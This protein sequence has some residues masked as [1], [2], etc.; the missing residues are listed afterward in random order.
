MT[1]W[2]N[3]PS[4]YTNGEGVSG[5]GDFFFGFPHHILG[6]KFAFGLVVLIWTSFFGL[7]LAARSAKAML[8]ASFI[9]FVFA[10]FLWLRGD[11]TIVVPIVLIV[12]T[13]I[14]AIGSKEGGN[15]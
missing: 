4:N 9:S 13:I 11:L 15:L 7:M 14:G 1:N 5:V 8:V 2:W 12:L 6:A 10:V 3:Y